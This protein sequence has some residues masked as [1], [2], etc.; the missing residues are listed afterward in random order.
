M[1]TAGPRATIISC[2]GISDSFGAK[3]TNGETLST[4]VEGFT[5]EKCGRPAHEQH[6]GA[7][8]IV[9]TGHPNAGLTL[10]GDKE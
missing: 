1:S 8:R 9:G 5:I 4:V 10:P 2:K 6:G 3:F 7:M